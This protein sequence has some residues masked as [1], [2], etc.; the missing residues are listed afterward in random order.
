L[1]YTDPFIPIVKAT[2]A[3][4]AIGENASQFGNVLIDSIL[5][6]LHWPGQISAL[7]HLIK[8]QQDR[9]VCSSSG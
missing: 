8:K 4:R 1:V 5:H 6:L 7:D 2:A 9:T 3:K